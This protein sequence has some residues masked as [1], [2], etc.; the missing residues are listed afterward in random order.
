MTPTTHTR[1][2]RRLTQPGTDQTAA[3]RR[4]DNE[5][6]T[7]KPANTQPARHARV[8]AGMASHGLA[9]TCCATPV[10]DHTHERT[11]TPRV[12]HSTTKQPTETTCFQPPTPRPHRLTI[13]G[14]ADGNLRTKEP[15][16]HTSSTRQPRTRQRQ[17]Q[18]KKPN[19]EQAHHKA[20]DTPKHQ[21]NSCG[22]N[23][24]TI[25]RPHASRPTSN[26]ADMQGSIQERRPTGRQH[27]GAP[28]P[29]TTILTDTTAHRS[30]TITQPT[31]LRQ[32]NTSNPRPPGR[33][34][35]R[36][37]LEA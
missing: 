31:D 35:A 32:R 28:S 15:T 23:D 25:N 10:C 20:A 24:T 14:C 37:S 9:T 3:E 19:D 2:I 26:Q 34:Q 21:P 27:H 4:S 36:P 29:S 7:R 1:T 22:N 8:E 11:T 13:T 16:A 5:Q 17:Q 6:T 33:A 30:S 18:Q 12:H